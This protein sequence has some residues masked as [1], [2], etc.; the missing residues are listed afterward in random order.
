M[1]RSELEQLAEAIRELCDQILR[2]VPHLHQRQ[3]HI[4]Q[5][6]SRA[7]RLAARSNDPGLRRVADLARIAAS[8]LDDAIRQLTTTGH[9]GH[10]YAKNLTGRSSA[11][12][13]RAAPSG[14][15]SSPQSSLN[16]AEEPGET[17]DVDDQVENG[18]TRRSTSERAAEA[19]EIWL[20]NGKEIGNMAHKILV[21]PN[22][23][24]PEPPRGSEVNDPVTAVTIPITA[25]WEVLAQWAK[26][27]GNDNNARG[28][29]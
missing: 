9:H 6:A 14:I 13:Q 10:D 1:T 21:E 20:S 12:P 19:R 5:L 23:K 7:T 4:G 2:D 24:A 29:C 3:H 25:L 8:Q 18:P 16:T 17:N 26:G 27:K 28:R 11:T 22:Y 15:A